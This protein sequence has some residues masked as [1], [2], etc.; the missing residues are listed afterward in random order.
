MLAMM[1]LLTRA[2]LEMMSGMAR[3]DINVERRYL[4]NLRVKKQN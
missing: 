4:S 1:M 2:V 3:H